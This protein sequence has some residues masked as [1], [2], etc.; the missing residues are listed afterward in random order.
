MISFITVY[1]GEF[2]INR[3][4]KDKIK[5]Y[6]RMLY[7]M[8]VREISNANLFSQLSNQILAMQQM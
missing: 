5:Q 6:E 4:K 7:L 1:Q 8:S 3:F 2:A